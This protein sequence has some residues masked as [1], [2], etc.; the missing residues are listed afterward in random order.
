MPLNADRSKKKFD[1][2]N[3][4]LNG[5]IDEAE[6][7]IRKRANSDE[8]IKKGLEDKIR[9]LAQL[10]EL[11]N[12]SPYTKDV[13]ETRREEINEK[14]NL[15]RRAMK[16]IMG[17]LSVDRPPDEIATLCASIDQVVQYNRLYEIIL[18]PNG[19]K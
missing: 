10:L 19:N 16:N 8:N 7:L 15:N 14:L 5:L 6:S 18:N 12:D 13:L 3:K 2:I 4:E 17:C 9:Y 1:D 11:Y